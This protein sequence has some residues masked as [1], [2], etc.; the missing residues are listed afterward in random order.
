MAKILVTGC[1]GTLG[2]PLVRE[3]TRRALR[4]RQ[5]Q[6]L[7]RMKKKLTSIQP[8]RTSDY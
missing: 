5:L 7:Q 2:T 3:L 8:D 4:R 1:K 6:R